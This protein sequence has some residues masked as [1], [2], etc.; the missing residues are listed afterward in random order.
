[1]IARPGNCDRRRFQLGAVARR[2][3]KAVSH[4]EQNIPE[5]ECFPFNATVPNSGNMAPEPCRT[6]RCG[7]AR[8]AH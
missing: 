1:M 6:A 5:A 8:A 3:V 2:I 4:I 7:G